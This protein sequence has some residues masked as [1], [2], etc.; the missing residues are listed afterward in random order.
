MSAA[1]ISI[2]NPFDGLGGGADNVVSGDGGQESNGGSGGGVTLF[3]PS[4]FNGSAAS[5]SPFQPGPSFGADD[6]TPGQLGAL[7]KSED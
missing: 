5:S 3:N 7:E 1:P 6:S 4:F 2:F